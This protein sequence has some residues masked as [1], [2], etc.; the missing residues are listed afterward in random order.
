MCKTLVTSL[1]LCNSQA[2]D[3]LAS[4]LQSFTS[5]RLRHPKLGL[6]TGS[7]HPLEQL[8]LRRLGIKHPCLST[9]QKSCAS[10]FHYVDLFTGFLISDCG[11]RNK[12]FFPNSITHSYQALWLVTC[13]VCSPISLTL[14]N[15]CPTFNPGYSSITTLSNESFNSG[16]PAWEYLAGFL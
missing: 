2:S 15:L 5:L 16:G 1:N 4:V 10:F 12:S 9:Q 14:H 8:H 6:C 7:T 3:F 11:S 13:T